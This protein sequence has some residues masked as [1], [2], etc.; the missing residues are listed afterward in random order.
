MLPYT[1]VPPKQHG[2]KHALVIA[3]CIPSAVCHHRQP[4]RLMQKQLGPF[5][6]RL[7][8][9]DASYAALTPAASAAA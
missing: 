6:T 9:Y 8:W 2:C 7:H 1:A 5:Y 3:A 4:T